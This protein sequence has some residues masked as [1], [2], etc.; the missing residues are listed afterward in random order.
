MK[1]RV[2][3]YIDQCILIRSGNGLKLII[4]LCVL[5][6]SLPILASNFLNVD[7]SEPDKQYHAS[8]SFVGCE[9]MMVLA[10][11]NDYLRYVAAPVL[12]LSIGYA[13]EV[14]DERFNQKDINADLIGIGSAVIFDLIVHKWIFR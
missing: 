14:T 10:G 1:K 3:K 2:W 4:T 6:L 9:T 13:K 11:D 7:F 5:I 12:M 8:G